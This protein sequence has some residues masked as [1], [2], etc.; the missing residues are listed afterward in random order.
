MVAKTVGKMVDANTFWGWSQD[1]GAMT[2]LAASLLVILLYCVLARAGRRLVHRHLGDSLLRALLLEA[3]VA[4]ELCAVA[5]ELAIVAGNYGV[6]VFAALLCL[7]IVWWSAQWGDASACPYTHLED[8]VEGRQDLGQAVLKIWAELAGGVLVFRFVQLLWSL[9]L[10]ENH[11][12]RAFAECSADLQVSALYGA[13][14]EGAATC[15]S[16][17]T[18]RA[19]YDLQPRFGTAIGSVIGTSLVVAALN[20]SG[21]YFNPMLAT[22]LKYGC[23]GHSAWEHVLVYWVGASAGSIASVFLYRLPAVQAVVR[24]KAD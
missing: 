18:S 1:R 11:R 20:H 15:L 24:R 19:I 9:E 23:R 2:P 6:P 21:G 16:R 10:T 4:A 8:V 3:L 7:L 13:L 17:L 14:V 5:S 12:G 22:V